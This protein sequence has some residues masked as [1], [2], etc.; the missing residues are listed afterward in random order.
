VELGIA[1][2]GRVQ[3]SVL[4]MIQHVVDALDLAR[5]GYRCTALGEAADG[6]AQ[7]DHI[8]IGGDGD[9]LEVSE[10]LVR[11]ER[12]RDRVFEFGV[13]GHGT[14]F[15]FVSRQP[16]AELAALT[17]GPTRLVKSIADELLGLEPRTDL[18]MALRP[19]LIQLVATLEHLPMAPGQKTQHRPDGTDLLSF[20]HPLR[21]ID[22]VFVG[23]KIAELSA[24]L[25]NR[26]VQRG[27]DAWRELAIGLG[28]DRITWADA[29]ASITAL[30]IQ[31]T[32]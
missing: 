28:G 24:I 16:G 31:Q 21:R 29:T 17:Y 12:A 30:L 4:E 2:L 25:A 11:A 18:A 27:D 5:G 13:R 6:A 3:E 20:D 32:A 9:L 23:D 8:V 26:L 7:R 10:P 1:A 15:G 22:G 19:G 14:S